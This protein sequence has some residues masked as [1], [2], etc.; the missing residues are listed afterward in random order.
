M[1]GYLD[2]SGRKPSDFIFF[3]FGFFGFLVAATG[4]VLTSPACAL[5]GAAILLLAIWSF[6]E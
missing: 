3:A 5:V 1:N 2:S 4:I 6:G